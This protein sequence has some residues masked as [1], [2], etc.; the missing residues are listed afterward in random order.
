MWIYLA[1]GSAI[2]VALSQFFQK[3]ALKGRDIIDFLTI[4][5]GLNFILALIVFLFSGVSFSFHH[6][7]WIMVLACTDL[8]GTFL[9]STALK[10]EDISL[11]TP[12]LNFTPLPSF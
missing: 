12:F 9:L 6:T 7:G 11:V 1:L 5:L 4:S 8:G 10:N 2:F 3:K